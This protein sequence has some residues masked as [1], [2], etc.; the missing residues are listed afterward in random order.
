MIIIFYAILISIIICTNIH[1][2]KKRRRKDKDSKQINFGT[3]KALD[4]NDS[5][6]QKND[7]KLKGTLKNMDQKRVFLKKKNVKVTSKLDKNILKTLCCI[8]MDAGHM[9]S[10]VLNTSASSSS[11][12][13]LSSFTSCSSSSLS[14]GE[15]DADEPDAK[16]KDVEDVDKKEISTN[17]SCDKRMRRREENIPLI[18]I[19]H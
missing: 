7:D 4:A 12:S 15:G 5:F 6:Y 17:D 18:R 16:K 14:D 8:D 11:L 1:R 19:N 2:F 13:S 10:L 9:S 3:I